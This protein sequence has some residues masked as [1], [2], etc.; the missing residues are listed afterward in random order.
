LIKKNNK[1]NC[2]LLIGDGPIVTKII[3]DIFNKTP[4]LFM[5][6]HVNKTS[7]DFLC[8][9]GFIIGGIVHGTGLYCPYS[10]ILQTMT[11][12][13]LQTSYIGMSL[14]TIGLGNAMWKGETLQPLRWNNDGIQQC[15]NGMSYN[16]K[17]RIMDQSVWAGI[18]V[19]AGCVSFYKYGT[20]SLEN[21]AVTGSLYDGY[22]CI[23]INERNTK[24]MFVMMLLTNKILNVCSQ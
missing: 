20:S 21:G 10:N 2:S 7:F 18:A 15:V 19:A 9:I 24:R 5:L 12:F 17:V 14:G 22:T 16:Y 13:S 1:S 8:P 4:K 3:A 11:T 6:Y 23:A